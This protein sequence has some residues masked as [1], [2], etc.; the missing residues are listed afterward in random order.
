MTYIWNSLAEKYKVRKKMKRQC[1]QYLS[2]LEHRLDRAKIMKWQA[3]FR[4]KGVN[5]IQNYVDNMHP[6]LKME[7]DRLRSIYLAADV[8]TVNNMTARQRKEFSKMYGELCSIIF[9][10]L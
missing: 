9:Y 3:E 7:I 10:V 1:K 8:L 6:A 2:D 5:K 4:S